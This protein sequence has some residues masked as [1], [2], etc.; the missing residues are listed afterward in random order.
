M[1]STT[2]DE[3]AC[4]DV[5]RGGSRSF[6]AAAL[7]LPRRIHLPATALY[8]FCRV[9]DDAIDQ[10]GGGLAAIA[11]LRDRLDRI[12][13]GRPLAH[14]ADRA[15][16]ATVAR[17]AVP[18][19]LPD[20][21]LDGFAWDAQGRRY[22]TLS[23]LC[24]YAARVAGTVGAMM[25]VLMNA[26]APDL[27]ARACDLGVA[28]QLTNIARDV[29]EDA[30]NGRLYLPLAWLRDAGIEPDAFLAAPAFSPALGEVVRRLLREAEALYAR[31]D[32]GIARLPLAC[33]P[34]IGAA[35]LL[36]AEIGREVA[37]RGYDSVATRARVP[38]RRKLV[39][40]ARA[41][42]A[43]ARPRER[44]ADPALPSVRFLVEAVANGAT[45]RAV[46][47]RHALDLDA[48]IEW[49]LAL[50]ERLDQR[51]FDGAP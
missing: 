2:S 4:R 40:L 10:D 45:P 8:A 19:T 28:M 1:M 13:A 27:V 11:A 33:R 6:L 7:V 42:L 47:R 48:R 36:Y 41:A 16:A 39:L 46:P 44:A 26:R 17:H 12:Y 43:A 9:A 31:A 3:A 25:A 38:A 23:D 21:L 50:F 51:Q 20:A 22:E 32:I 35:R 24:D 34:G 5:L 18:R 49:L 14:P 37:R 29:G 15:L 30:R